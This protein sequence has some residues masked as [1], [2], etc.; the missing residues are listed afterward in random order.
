[1]QEG[2]QNI[3]VFSSTT[4]RSSPVL[5]PMRTSPAGVQQ[6]MDGQARSQLSVYS[7][8]C[9]ASSPWSPA[10]ADT[11]SSRLALVV[12]LRADPSAS[13]ASFVLHNWSAFAFGGI[14]YFLWNDNICTTAVL[15]ILTIYRKK[16]CLINH[17]TLHYYI[18]VTKL[19]SN[20]KSRLHHHNILLTRSLAIT[21][22][23]CDCCIILKS[24][25]YTK[26]IWSW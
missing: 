5:Q 19:Q 8:N 15:D 6:W 17:F 21:K 12:T 20:C 9:S 14:L 23:P 22:R 24:G 13:F 10:T 18:E 1:M 25:S 11:G 3:K 7:S 4:L 16:G 26:A 2:V